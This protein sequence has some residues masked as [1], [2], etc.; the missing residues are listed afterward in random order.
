M[1]LLYL[2]AQVAGL[3]FHVIQLETANKKSQELLQ[4]KEVSQ[5]Q[6]G[7]RHKETTSQLENSKTQVTEL[8]VQVGLVEKKAQSLEE[9]LGL[10]HAKCRDLEHQLVR[11]YSALRLT[12]GINHSRISDKSG[13]RKRSPSPWRRN[14]YAKGNVELLP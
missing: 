12:V 1:S 13:L 2:F 7:Q 6:S 4:E 3:Q 14:L 10:S 11:L 8:S 5:Q 9:Q